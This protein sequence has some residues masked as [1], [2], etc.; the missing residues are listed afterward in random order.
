MEEGDFFFPDG[1]LVIRVF[2]AEF[3]ELQCDDK[4]IMR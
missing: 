1:T 3:P 4:M 2:A